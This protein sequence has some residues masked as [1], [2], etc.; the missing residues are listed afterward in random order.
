M[1]KDETRKQYGKA[2]ARRMFRVLSHHEMND[3]SRY[4][5]DAA[6]WRVWRHG[7]GSFHWNAIIAGTSC[8]NEGAM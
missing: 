5:Q 6:F 1:L 8:F 4:W 3:W 2:E 7:N